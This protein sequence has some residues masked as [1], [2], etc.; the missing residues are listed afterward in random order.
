MEIKEFEKQEKEFFE[1][2]KKIV[3]E[4]HPKWKT[5]SDREIKRIEKRIDKK[6]DEL[7]EKVRNNRD[8]DDVPENY[9]YPFVFVLGN[10]TNLFVAVEYWHIIHKEV[11]TSVVVNK[12]YWFRHTD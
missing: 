6:A 4:E 1:E 12:V 10:A 5:F 3:F 2:I 7:R 9:Y 8:K 11:K